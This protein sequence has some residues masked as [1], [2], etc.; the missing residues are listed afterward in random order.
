MNATK[1][2]LKTQFERARR[3]GWIPFFEEAVRKTTKG[4]F[5]V[6]DLLA[7]G[8]RETNLDPKWLKK[9]GDG[10]H[11]FGL[12]QIDI[13]SFPEFT[14]GSGWQDAR[15]G[16]LFGAEVLMQKWNDY[17]SGIGKRRTVKGKSYTGKTAENAQTAQHIAISGYNCG[18]WSQY[19]YALARDID[20]FSTGKD[21]GADVMAR[22]AVFRQLLKSSLSTERIEPRGSNLLDES[23]QTS[24][25]A[26]D[27]VQTDSAINS[28]DVQQ[29][30]SDK[31]INSAPQTTGE[32]APSE[33]TDTT[34]K[35]ESV[36]QKVKTVGDTIST[37]TERASS[38]KNSFSPISNASWFITLTV[39]IGGWILLVKAFVADNLLE[40]V[41][42]FGL[43]VLAVW[44]FNQSKNRAVKKEV[45]GQVPITAIK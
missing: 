5:D 24:V 42:G 7:I 3:L 25:E 43:I 27:E 37:Y 2:Q 17:V 35:T 41:V 15:A 38:V 44:Y 8:S 36:M 10:G 6:S 28:G 9:A 29:G 30:E 31:A 18:R 45:A 40:V 4:Y 23:A 26:A 32:D 11:G 19:C 12:L 20:S 14:R 33:N 34:T 13:G 22:A 21:Y 39:K 1:A 16:I